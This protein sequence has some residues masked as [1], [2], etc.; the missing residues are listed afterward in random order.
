MSPATQHA[1]TTSAD[2]HVLEGLIIADDLTGAAD[3]AV[4][5]AVAGMSTRVLF[6]GAGGPSQG[7]VPTSALGAGGIQVLAV[8]T[9]SRRLAPRDART[10]VAA[11]LR[12]AP[13]ARLRM[14]KID[15]TLR[16]N[17]GEE[18]LAAL[19]ALGARLAICA[20]AF[21]AADRQTRAGKQWAA[22]RVVGD[23]AACFTGIS[24]AH[25]P[26]RAVRAG[27]SESLLDRAAAAGTRVV[28]VDATT[29][30]DLNAVV[31]AGRHR[32]DVVW[33]GSGGLGAALARATSG[34]DDT[35]DADAASVGSRPLPLIALDDPVL[36]VVGSATPVAAAQATRVV[37]RGAR[38]VTIPVSALISGAAPVGPWPQQV[39]DALQDRRDVV[40]RI[41]E[42]D[43]IVPGHG[44][45]IVE[46]LADAVAPVLH[47]IPP[48]AL[49]ATGG[50]TA[51]AFGRSLGAHGLDVIA[52]LE[53]GVVYS[54]LV[55][56][57]SLPLVT[58][59]GAFGDP[60]TLAR[61]IEI[62]RPNDRLEG[63]R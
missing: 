12:G 20:P 49:V 56:G 61:T 42:G 43:T 30:D 38:E 34:Q 18:T 15:S 5:F 46:A 1:A 54:R 29:Q 39:G 32:D 9:D 47:R 16:G 57:S 2:G 44:R 63:H 6:A 21:P 31:E 50:E 41:D 23:V 59:A 25:I 37:A 45:A 55:G 36:T 4:A 7:D 33:V 51:L 22:G 52:E 13:T 28:V 26:L 19:E 24:T 53:P 17:L 10:T 27:A 48:A 62:L 60:G 14:K 8:D 3:S 35:S 11:A 40:L 58:K